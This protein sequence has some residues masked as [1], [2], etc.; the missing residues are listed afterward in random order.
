MP[1]TIP[2]LD[3]QFIATAFCTAVH[4]AF[5]DIGRILFS[6]VNLNCSAI[7][8]YGS[9]CVHFFCIP[10]GCHFYAKSPVFGETPYHGY[11]PEG[12]P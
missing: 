7:Q 1:Y 9:I 10:L 5:M 4:K 6:V 2:T 12:D 11:V 8:K 3:Q